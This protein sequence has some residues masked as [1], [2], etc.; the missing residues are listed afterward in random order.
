M[1]HFRPFRYSHFKK[2]TSEDIKT[3]SSSVLYSP[4]ECTACTNQ[5]IVAPRM[6]RQR[7]LTIVGLR[8]T[9][10]QQERRDAEGEDLKWGVDPEHEG[11]IYTLV[12]VSPPLASMFE[13]VTHFFTFSL[14]ILTFRTKMKEKK[15]FSVRHQSIK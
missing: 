8:E 14:V 1:H 13:D 10:N 12:R 6:R 9:A 7:R 11:L 2:K 3:D 4:P 5:R 15:Y